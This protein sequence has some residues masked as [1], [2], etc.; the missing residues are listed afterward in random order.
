MTYLTES[1][2]SWDEQTCTTIKSWSNL[3]RKDV[4]E[5]SEMKE[6]LAEK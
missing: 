4:D 1:T 6:H 3:T 5:S 2:S